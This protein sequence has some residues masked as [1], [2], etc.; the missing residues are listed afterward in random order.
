MV[1]N[2]I[3][4]ARADDLPGTYGKQETNKAR[5]ALMRL[6]LSGKRVLVIGSEFPWLEACLLE[7]GAAHVTTIEYSSIVSQHPQITV[8]LPSTVREM[9]LNGTLKP[10]DGVATYSSIEH[11]GL[12]RYGDGLNPWGDIQQ[13]AKAWCI[14]KPGGFLM[15]GIPTSHDDEIVWNAHRIYGPNVLP[16]LTANWE[17][18]WEDPQG[19][20]N[21]AVHLYR[22]VSTQ[23]S[24]R[25]GR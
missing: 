6:D 18:I 25:C 5:R 23:P 12:G 3:K 14:T 1:E 4:L 7:R 10:F 21:H 22:K 17:L 11:T 2:D 20:D 19:Y 16:H 15:L 9:Y 13:L 24:S 8:L